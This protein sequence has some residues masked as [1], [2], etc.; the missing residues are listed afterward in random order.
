MRVMNVMYVLYV[1]Y[2]PMSVCTYVRMYA[3][4]YRILQRWKIS[5]SVPSSKLVRVSHYFHSKI[6]EAMCIVMLLRL[7]CRFFQA[8]IRVCHQ[9]SKASR[10]VRIDSFLADIAPGHLCVWALGLGCQ[11]Y[12][13]LH[14]HL[15]PYFQHFF[16]NASCRVLVL[17]ESESAAI[18]N[19]TVLCIKTIYCW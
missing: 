4:A 3:Y 19:R 1:M 5:E 13:A 11:E 2:V 8:Q 9:I 7:I 12:M 14:K 16:P 15:F 6:F 17:T 18:Q 10:H